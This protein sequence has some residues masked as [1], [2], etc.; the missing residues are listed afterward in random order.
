[1]LFGIAFTFFDIALIIVLIACG[2]TGSFAT[3]RK[4]FGLAST[5][6]LVGIAVA[7]LIAWPV[8]KVVVA[9]RGWLIVV[10]DCIILYIVAGLVT[11]FIYWLFY[12][13]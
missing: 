5:A 3:G 12:C 11:S 6:T 9:E 1:M 10:S 4:S 8:L 7:G 13:W 2:L